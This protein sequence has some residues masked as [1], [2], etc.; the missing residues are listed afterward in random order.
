VPKIYNTLGN[1]FQSDR[2][3][4]VIYQ[5]CFAIELQQAG[6]EFGREIV[7]DIFY[8]N[9]HVGTRRAGSIVEQDIVLEIKAVINLEGVHLVQAKTI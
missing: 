1:G 3:A 6:L 5:R 4:E 9:I 8:G 7:Q 2:R